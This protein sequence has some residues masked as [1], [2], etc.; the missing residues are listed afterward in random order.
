MI[1]FF[2]EKKWRLAIKMIN[3]YYEK[4]IFVVVIS[5]TPHQVNL[6]PIGLADG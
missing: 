5:I 4:P 2:I 6:H 3:Y 1:K